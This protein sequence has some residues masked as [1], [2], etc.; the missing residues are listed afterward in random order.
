MSNITYKNLVLSFFDQVYN[1]KNLDTVLDLFNDDYYEHRED[2]ARSNLD[3]IN[4][5]KGAFSIFPDLRCDVKDIVC[6]E[7]DVFA[8]VVFTGTHRGEFLGVQPKDKEIT[9]EAM[10]QFRIRNGKI[11]ESWGSWP[12]YD[13]VQKLQSKEED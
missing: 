10:E 13:I 1:K 8:R 2:G 6:E 12:L 7:D 5:I 9:F 11:S 4:I 3:A